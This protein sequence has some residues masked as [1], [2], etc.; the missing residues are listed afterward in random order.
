MC[1]SRRKQ[2]LVGLIV[3][4]EAASFKQGKAS[5]TN[6]ELHTVSYVL[7]ILEAI[8]RLYSLPEC[9]EN[10]YSQQEMYIFSAWFNIGNQL[11]KKNT[12]LP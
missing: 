5:T 7:M 11:Y 12:R 8:H 3:N 6:Q 9:R 1:L 4:R 10:I 2:V